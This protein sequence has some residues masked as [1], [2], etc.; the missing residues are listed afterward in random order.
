MARPL[1]IEYS[2]ATHHVTSRGNERRDIFRDDEDRL[3]FL[4]FLGEATRRFGWIVTAWVLMTNHYH[5]VIETPQPNLSRGMHWLNTRYAGWFNARYRRSGHL[6]QGRFKS[7]LVEKEAYLAEVLR[8]V[9]LNPMRA[10]M[11]GRPED[12]R[13]SSY[14]ATAGLEAAPDWLNVTAALESFQGEE[15][16]G[17]YRAFV[18]AGIGCEDNL[19]EQ[20]I[21][22]IYLG[23]ESWARTIRAKVESKPRST[24]YPKA[25]RAVGRPAMHVIAQTVARIART[26]V[27]QLRTRRGSPLRG[28]VA[29]I[30]WHE[31]L[32]TLRSIAASLRLRSEGHVSNLIR[33]CESLFA[34]DATLLGQLDSALASLR[35]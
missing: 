15:A 23:G 1:R 3:A 33:R 7:V 27:E 8:Y 13:W 5:L 9:V 14:R 18:L 19:W 21:H 31:G 10:R 29:W 2:G 25:H 35:A 32:V 34:K 30:G 6:F 22:G 11:V 24:D 28:L 4:R 16:E 12:Y 17:R 26:T 20:L